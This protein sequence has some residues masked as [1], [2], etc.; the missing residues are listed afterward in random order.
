[1]KAPMIRLALLFALVLLMC[2]SMQ[3]QLPI[4]TSLSQV[5]IPFAFM[6]GGVHLPAGHY[7]VYHPGDPYLLVIEKD[8]GRARA[9][10]YVHPSD[11]SSDEADARLVFN[12]YEDQYF[13]AQIWH[14][15]D[16]EVHDCFKCE[17]EKALVAQGGQPQTAVVTAKR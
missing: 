16:R 8:D 4:K 3:A 2:A 9:V 1:M 6:A 11:V 13:L 5:D 10:V 12:R 7:H 17:R 14:E 15:S